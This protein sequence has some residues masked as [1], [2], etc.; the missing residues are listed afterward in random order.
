MA[1]ALNPGATVNQRVYK[2]APVNIWS[3][4]GRWAVFFRMK[5]L[6]NQSGYAAHFATSG[7]AY[8]TV[9]RIN[10]QGGAGGHLDVLVR[11][12]AADLQARISTSAACPVS[13][14]TTYS[15][16]VLCD[17]TD[18][19]GNLVSTSIRIFV[20]T[21]TGSMTEVSYGTTGGTSA[22][23]PSANNTTWD[24]GNR[25]DLARAPEIN[26]SDYMVWH[27]GGV[28]PVLSASDLNALDGGADP[29][30]ITV[31][32]SL[33]AF[34][35]LIGGILY[36]VQSDSDWSSDNSPAGTTGVHLPISIGVPDEYPISADGYWSSDGDRGV[37]ASSAT[38]NNVKAILD[39]SGNQ[40][41]M[42][43]ATA[44]SRPRIKGDAQRSM[45]GFCIPGG[46]TNNSSSVNVSNN[47]T[48]DMDNADVTWCGIT[49]VLT[50]D[51][52]R[53]F[54]NAGGVTVGTDASG[55][56]AVTVGGTQYTPLPIQRAE[57]YPQPWVVTIGG[58]KS[59]SAVR[60]ITLRTARGVSTIN[61]NS[62]AYSAAAISRIGPNPT[63]GDGRH[64]NGMMRIIYHDSALSEANQQLALDALIEIAEYHSNPTG[65]LVYAGS[66]T[67]EG[68]NASRESARGFCYWLKYHDPDLPYALIPDA[69]FGT[70]L[71][72]CRLTLAGTGDYD[73]GEG[74]TQ[75]AATG[76]VVYQSGNSLYL[77]DVS[78]TFDTTGTVP[79]IGDD[80]STSRNSTANSN[81]GTGLFSGTRYTR[82]KE[83][84]NAYSGP[85]WLILFGSSNPVNAGWDPAHVLEIDKNCVARIKGEVAN[86][87]VVMQTNIPRS[88]FPGQ[89]AAHQTYNQ[90]LRDNISSTYWDDVIDTEVI[91]AFD[92]D[93]N[94]GSDD[95]IA[96]PEY[97]TDNAFRDGIHPSETGLSAMAALGAVVVRYVVGKA[98][99]VLRLIKMGLL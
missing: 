4:G 23:N 77:R 82:L 43:H 74:V 20:G 25:P 3:S 33:Q 45:I 81:L 59:G 51:G 60:T 53:E 30:D 80:S 69:D 10:G 65:V 67:A 29:R 8:G 14:T 11:C 42:Y 62:Y 44:T 27:G 83:T 26:V 96:A 89:N 24:I 35:P 57:G 99:T 6:V 47:T 22:A 13:S 94:L 92:F 32:A 31:T 49:H 93:P 84:L 88:T 21:G 87:N 90:S 63:D 50:C 86:L 56:L 34:L 12:G 16:A 9:V 28:S 72:N 97:E 61:T 76:V 85:K 52:S 18:G 2:N 71:V 48:A 73:I 5:N 41:H 54:V 19:S 39:I 70:G 78:G 58:T 98:K 36:D 95:S 7:N 37:Y 15:V 40:R 75:G 1:I 64:N 91:D 68:N 66:S 55:N 17:G 46:T 79:L 38:E